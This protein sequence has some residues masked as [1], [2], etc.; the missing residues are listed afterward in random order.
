MIDLLPPN[1]AN[2]KT[3]VVGN[4][5]LSADGMWVAVQVVPPASFGIAGMVHI[6]LGAVADTLEQVAPTLNTRT[7]FPQGSDSS[8]PYLSEDGQTVVFEAR[9]GSPSAIIPSN[10]QDSPAVYAWSPRSDPTVIST[11]L[12]VTNLQLGPRPM[13]ELLAASDTTEFVAYS[14]YQPSAIEPTLG[15]AHH[16]WVVHR[17]T[18]ETRRLTRAEFSD[19][20]PQPSFSANGRRIAF[21][22]ADPGLGVRRPQRCAGRVPAIRN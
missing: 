5:S 7:P 21:V 13:G 1:A 11:N 15:S 17:P 9:Q 8:G 6:H 14:G 19:D 12:A 4:P 2:Q 18:L 16:L 10:L 20:A 22:S 3:T